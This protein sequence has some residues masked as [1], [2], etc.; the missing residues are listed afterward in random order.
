MDGVIK[1]TFAHFHVR[2]FGILK[3]SG[4]QRIRF[5][6][7]R[8]K[9][10]R[11]WCWEVNGHFSLEEERITNGG[12]NCVTQEFR[13]GELC[14]GSGTFGGAEGGRYAQEVTHAEGGGDACPPHEG[15]RRFSGTHAGRCGN[16]EGGILLVA[17]GAGGGGY[18]FLEIIHS[19]GVVVSKG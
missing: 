14:K 19:R 1:D 18:L 12:K 8:C 17:Q 10:L 2:N 9:V 16:A 7:Y 13:L 4:L 11:C 3:G 5:G 6:E 15:A